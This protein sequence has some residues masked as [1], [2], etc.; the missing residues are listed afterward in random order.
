MCFGHFGNV[1]LEVVWVFS[2]TELELVEVDR[3]LF[4]GALAPGLG[5]H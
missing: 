5:D 3:G 1:A 4:D 2:D